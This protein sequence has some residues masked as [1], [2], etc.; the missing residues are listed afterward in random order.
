MEAPEF[1]SSVVLVRPIVN[2]AI[3]CF[4]LVTDRAWTP[5][6]L[7]MKILN[8]GA[9]FHFQQRA[10]GVGFAEFWNNTGQTD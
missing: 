7:P 6:A 4:T 2:S 5:K 1:G 3:Q 9:F 8:H 10:E